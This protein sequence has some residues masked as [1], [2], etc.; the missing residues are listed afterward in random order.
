MQ[1]LRTKGLSEVDKLI[2]ERRLEGQNIRQIA[3]SVSVAPSTV[4]QTLRRFEPELTET[5][6]VAGLG[7]DKAI[8]KLA[9]LMEQKKRFSSHTKGW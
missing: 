7:L 6:W 2:L 1:T 4:C 9:Q 3:D 8:E 5:L